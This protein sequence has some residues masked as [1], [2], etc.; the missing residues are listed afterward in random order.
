MSKAQGF[1][2]N[3][4][5]AFIYPDKYRNYKIFKLDVMVSA[6]QKYYNLIDYSIDENRNEIIYSFNENI[7]KQIINN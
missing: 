5:R 6:K 1:L 4:M 2:A 7:K 3:F